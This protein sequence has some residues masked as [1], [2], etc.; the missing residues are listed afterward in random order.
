[1]EVHLNYYFENS[2]IV[3]YYFSKLFSYYFLEVPIGFAMLHRTSNNFSTNNE[4]YI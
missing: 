4:N 2:I 3:Y 1:M